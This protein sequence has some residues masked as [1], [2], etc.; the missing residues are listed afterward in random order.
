MDGNSKLSVFL[1]ADFRALANALNI[2]SILWCSL[3]PSALILRLHLALSL[4][5]LKKWKNISEG[6]SPIVRLLKFSFPHKP[7]SASEINGNLCKAIIHWQNEAV[8]FNSFF[9]AQSCKKCFTQADGKI[10]NKM[11]GINTCISPGIYDEIKASMPGYLVKH[12]IKKSDPGAYIAL[13]GS[14]K[15]KVNTDIRLFGFPVN[16]CDP[17]F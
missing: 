16:G 2:A 10:F 9:A 5:D 1:T 4:N 15:I 17:G 13:S 14:I 8:A 6:I 11:V 7:G 3:L 12:V